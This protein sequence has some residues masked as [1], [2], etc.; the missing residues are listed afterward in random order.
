M[1]EIRIHGRGGQVA[2]TTSQ[3][4]AIAAF[5]DGKQSQGFPAFG[6]ERRGA[7]SNSFVRIDDII[8]IRFNHINYLFGINIKIGL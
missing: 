3:L 7:P 2:V 8:Q 5:E 4:L 6:V 1:I